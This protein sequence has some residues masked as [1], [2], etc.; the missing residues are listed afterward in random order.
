MNEKNAREAS[1]I[2][3]NRQL[4]KFM[5]TNWKDKEVC[6]ASADKT[7]SGLIRQSMTSGRT[8]R[9]YEMNT[10]QLRKICSNSA[11]R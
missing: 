8:L 9:A 4:A 1:Q 10:G 2:I 5:R 7:F 11:H 3:W 6:L